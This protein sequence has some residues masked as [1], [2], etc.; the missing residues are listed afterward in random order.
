MSRL[1][2]M[3][4]SSGWMVRGGSMLL[5]SSL[6]LG[7]Y[8]TYQHRCEWFPGLCE[9][10][11]MQSRPVIISVSEPP[12]KPLAKVDPEK[13]ST[14]KTFR[15]AKRKQPHPLKTSTPNRSFTPA[16]AS[17]HK[18]NHLEKVVDNRF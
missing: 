8:T 17:V 9:Q 1:S 2:T 18:E 7:L 14:K 3:A 6:F 16:E 5:A 11:V 13:T 10:K 4:K 12:E 15:K